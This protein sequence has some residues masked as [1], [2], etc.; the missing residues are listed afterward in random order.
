MNTTDK[1]VAGDSL[2]IYDNGLRST[3]RECGR[4]SLAI[5]QPNLQRIEAKLS[6][7]TKA[8]E[9]KEITKTFEVADF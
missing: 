4:R 7:K 6:P 8:T 2:A 1:D 5:S 9:R 3:C